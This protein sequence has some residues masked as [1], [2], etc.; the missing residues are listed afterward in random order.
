M[1]G[2]VREAYDVAIHPVENLDGPVL[3]VSSLG[4]KLVCEVGVDDRGEDPKHSCCCPAISWDT[5]GF[6]LQQTSIASHEADV[7][8]DQCPSSTRV[9]NSIC[10]HRLPASGS[11][12]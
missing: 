6:T 2:R 7:P 4:L 1:E 5:G 11:S 3:E 9:P 12:K 8:V 10:L